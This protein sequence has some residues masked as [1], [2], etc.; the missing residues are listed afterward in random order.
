MRK[1]ERLF[2]VI[3]LAADAYVV[4][5]EC[6]NENSKAEG[7]DQV[8]EIGDV[9]GKGKGKHRSFHIWVAAA[10]TLLLVVGAVGFALGSLRIG[11]GKTGDNHIKGGRTG[12]EDGSTSFMSYAG[13]VFPLTF[14]EAAEGMTAVRN[15]TYRLTT[16]KSGYGMK[17]VEVTDVYEL[18]NHSEKD[19]TVNAYYPY[20]G[21]FDRLQKVRPSVAVEGNLQKT[22]LVVGGSCGEATDIL[23]RNEPSREITSLDGWEDYRALLAGADYFSHALQDSEPFSLSVIVYEFTDFKAPLEKYPAASQSI[24]FS[25]NR[26]ATQVYSYGF[27]G[28]S[29][30][31]KTGTCHYSYFVPKEDNLNRQKKLLIIIGEDIGAYDLA[32]YQDGGCEPGEEIDGVSCT[33]TR[34]KSTMEQVLEELMPQVGSD[35]MPKEGKL[36]LLWEEAVKKYVKQYMEQYAG[37]EWAAC[38]NGR[39]EELLTEPFYSDR[40]F[41]EV[42]PLTIPAGSTVQ[43]TASMIKEPSFDY[44]CS[45]AEKVGVAGYDMVTR[46]GSVLEFEKVTAGLEH[47]EHAE[48]VNQNYGFDLAQGITRVELDPAKEHYYME[49]QYWK[50]EE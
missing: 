32:G 8:E 15:I 47:M 39:M 34:R 27:E 38:G 42:F 31:D 24:G 40:V 18:T 49:I 12:C 43:V 23:Q 25:I 17:D 44:H 36:R 11:D 30:D 6:V 5:A 29:W 3:G 33:V 46:L 21:G 22:A 19:I 28:F 2:E 37:L 41:Y 10:A 45:N 48:I 1:E 4:E 50:E 35:Y 14:E 7:I 20:A 26:K 13:P 16:D 9:R